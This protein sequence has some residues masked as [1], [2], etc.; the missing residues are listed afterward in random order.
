MWHSPTS[1]TSFASHEFVIF[2]VVGDV[3]GE[4]AKNSCCCVD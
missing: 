1:S 2:E 3:A 4:M